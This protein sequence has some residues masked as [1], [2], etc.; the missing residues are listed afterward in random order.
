MQS[1]SMYTKA[2]AAK[3]TDPATEFSQNNSN[4]TPVYIAQKAE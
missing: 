3:A 4:S 2:T 1:Q